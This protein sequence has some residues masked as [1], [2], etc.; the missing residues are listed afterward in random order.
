MTSEEIQMKK[1]VVVGAG[2]FGREVAQLARHKNVVKPEWE[3]LGFVDDNR[4]LEGK[5]INGFQVLGDIDWLVANAEGKHAVFAFGE[6]ELKRTVEA[7][8][9][10]SGIRYATLIHPFTV[11]GNSVEIG[12]GTIIVAGVVLTVDIKIGRHVI[13][14]ANSC[15]GHDA[16]FGDYVT[17]AACVNVMGEVTIGEGCYVASGVTIRDAVTI[18]KNSIIGLGAVVVGDLPADI[19]ALGCPAKIVRENITGKVFK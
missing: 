12:E 1:L 2:G 5:I 7:R 9:Q 3:I 4:D 14:N 15:A 13:I 10:G 6:P 19:V 17:I 11:I 18:G 16:N 8:L